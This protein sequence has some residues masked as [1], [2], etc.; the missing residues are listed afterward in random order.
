[1]PSPSLLPLCLPTGWAVMF[2][3]LYDHTIT[4]E[5]RDWFDEDL[6]WLMRVQLDQTGLHRVTGDIDVGW[7]P[8]EDLQGTY[9]VY[10]LGA[11][12]WEDILVD[13][14]SRDLV[15]VARAI[16]ICAQAP[17]EN[18]QAAQ[19]YFQRAWHVHSS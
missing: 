11:G 3:T 9:R 14:S 15:E 4:P 19:S 6:L 16:T 7:Y 12:G 13:F 1:M 2:N 8:C 18:A 10:L 17:L 5:N